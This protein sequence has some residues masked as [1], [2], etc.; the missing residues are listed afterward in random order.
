MKLGSVVVAAVVILGLLY[1]GAE[2]YIPAPD[3]L[4]GLWNKNWQR[5]VEPRID[6]LNKTVDRYRTTPP[7]PPQG[8]PANRAGLNHVADYT[9][10]CTVGCAAA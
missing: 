10:T 1:F 7:A 2:G 3:W 8:L 9:V 5:Q 6:E 4:R